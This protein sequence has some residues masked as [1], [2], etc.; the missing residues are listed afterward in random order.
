MSCSWE[1]WA[2]GIDV[3]SIFTTVKPAIWLAA[4]WPFFWMKH[5][6]SEE[7]IL[8]C[9]GCFLHFWDVWMEKYCY[10]RPQ[11]IDVLMLQ[12]FSFL[13]LWEVYYR[14]FV[15]DVLYVIFN[16]RRTHWFNIKY[17]HLCH[18]QKFLALIPQYNN[19]NNNNN[20]DSNNMILT[21]I[22]ILNQRAYYF[23]HL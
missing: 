19:N 8:F 6:V 15:T 3:D 2:S 7:R 23:S 9:P 10:H 17:R 1:W 4:T 18:F 12:P 14:I 22:I 16:S 11:N 5:K 20:N 21:D 13:W